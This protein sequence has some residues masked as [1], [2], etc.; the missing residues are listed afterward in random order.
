[1]TSWKTHLCPMFNFLLR[2]SYCLLRLWVCLFVSV[3]QCSV[4][5]AGTFTNWSWSALEL[6]RWAAPWNW[7]KIVYSHSM[8][9]G[10]L[11]FVQLRRKKITWNSLTSL[12]C[13][14]RFLAGPRCPGFLF[15]VKLLWSTLAFFSGHSPQ[16]SL[17]KRHLPA[18]TPADQLPVHPPK[19]LHI[20]HTDIESENAQTTNTIP[21]SVTVLLITFP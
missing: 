21:A 9:K 7:H 5:R 16:C 11:M 3:P 6:N 13:S 2:F 19:S 18:Y 14:S 17:H 4:R 8:V 1:M 20:L 15:L 10:L 12:P